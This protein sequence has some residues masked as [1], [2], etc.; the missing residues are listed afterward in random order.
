MK[1]GIL[2]LSICVAGCNFSTVKVPEGLPP[3]Y[4]RTAVMRALESHEI[5]WETLRNDLDKSHPPFWTIQTAP[6][7]SM[8]CGAWG[9]FWGFPL[10]WYH[11]GI[12]VYY[13]RVKVLN[14]GYGWNIWLGLFS[15]ALPIYDSGGLSDSIKRELR[16][17]ERLWRTAPELS[18]Y[19]F[20]AEK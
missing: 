20:A 3:N 16:L 9:G 18:Q 11:H 15:M 10:Y 4:V 1:Q 12:E 7:Y 19:T 13:D 5:H 14:Y 17:S 2:L 6:H 8:T